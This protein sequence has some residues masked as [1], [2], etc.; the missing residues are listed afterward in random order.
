M[1]ENNYEIYQVNGKE[2]VFKLDLNPVNN[3]L[4]THIWIRHAVEPCNVVAAYFNISKQVYIE[5]YKRYEAYS[6][7]DN[8]TLFYF[9]K[10]KGKRIIIVTAMRGYQ[11]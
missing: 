1:L 8:V 7:T 5:K 10:Q 11:L 2:I 3:I 9:T 4:E 6:E